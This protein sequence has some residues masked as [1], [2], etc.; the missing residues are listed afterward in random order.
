MNT[1]KNVAIIV[2]SLAGGGAERIAGLLSKYLSSFYCVYLFV[3]DVNT[4]QYDFSGELVKIDITRGIYSEIRN[5]KREL[6]IHCAIS[7]GGMMNIANIRTKEHER[8]IVAH[9][10]STG[11]R[12]DEIPFV[13]EYY[14]YADL[15]VTCSEGVRQLLI[16]YAGI[17]SNY[18]VSIYN[19]IFGV[20][21]I[22]KAGY[23]ENNVEES[24]HDR[25]RFVMNAGRY[26]WE[27]NQLELISQFVYYHKHYDED[28]LL[29]IIGEGALEKELSK[30]IE[31]LGAGA[32]I[33]LIP[34]T[35][36]TPYYLRAKALVMTSV[37]EGLPN[38][39]YEAMCYGVPVISTDCYCGPREQLDDDCAYDSKITGYKLAKRGMLVQAENETDGERTHFFA[40]A[41]NR[42]LT[43]VELYE[44]TQK[45]IKDYI[46]N[47]FDDEITKEWRKII[48]SPMV[49]LLDIREKESEYERALSKYPV[50]I[51]YGAGIYGKRV[52]NVVNDGMHDIFFAISDSRP[53]ESV[54][55]VCVHYIADLLEYKENAIVL[56][57]AMRESDHTA[58]LKKARELGFKHIF[59][60]HM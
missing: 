6:N 26:T 2:Q 49:S 13:K 46:D 18:I 58:M 20:E 55:G 41:I 48:E 15:I 31:L 38:V 29:Y 10:N 23:R 51:I 21:D 47:Y 56:I 60:P 11:I 3:C 57:A 22:K 19:Y 36:L 5:K 33:K 34:F 32:Y 35:N 7:F 17:D 4:I 9:H 1:T 45:N 24:E 25:V 39:I 16:R 8:I 27:K 28:L 54:N 37:T 53:N 44:K 43:D 14:P 52:F 59:L 12:S 40:D 30:Q 42:M 50:I